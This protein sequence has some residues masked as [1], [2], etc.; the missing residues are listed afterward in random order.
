MIKDD[1]APWAPIVNTDTRDTNNVL[2][3]A[4][5]ECYPA[6]EI[7][8]MIDFGLAFDDNRYPNRISTL[9]D[10]GTWRPARTGT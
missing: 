4:V 10:D 2:G 9:R 7:P 6:Y 8:E 3:A 5:Q 1:A